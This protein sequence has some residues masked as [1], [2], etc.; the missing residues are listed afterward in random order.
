MKREMLFLG[1]AVLAGLPY[2]PTFAQTESAAL[3]TAGEPEAPA[4]V[5]AEPAATAKGPEMPN[6]IFMLIDDERALELELGFGRSLPTWDSALEA[7]LVDKGTTFE[8]FFNSTAYC[9][10]SRASYLTGMYS[11]NH[12]IWGNNYNVSLGNGGWRRFWELGHE[13]NS[14]GKWMQDAGYQTVLIGKFLNQYPNKPSNFLPETYVPAGWHEWYGSFT[15]DL[16]FSYFNFRMNQNGEVLRFGETEPAYLTDIERDLMV[17]YIQR[18]AQSG[19]PF[20][21]YL[22]PFAPHGPIEVA[23]RHLGMHSIP[24]PPTPPSFNEA[25]LSDKPLYVQEGGYIFP[26]FWS[27]GW[28]QRLDMSLALDEMI[29]ALFDTLAAEGVLDNTYVFFTSDN[30]LMWGEHQLDGKA[31]P[32]EESIRFPLLVR[33]PGVAEGITRNQLVA[34]VDVAPTLLEIANAAI[35]ASVDGESILGLIQGESQALDN[36]RDGVLVELNM[37]GPSRGE[38]EEPVVLGGEVDIVPSYQAVRTLGHMYIEYETGERELYDLVN[39]PYQMES[40]H[41]SAPATVLEALQKPLNALKDC[42]GADCAAASRLGAPTQM[43]KAEF[44]YLCHLL[45]CDFDASESFDLDGTLVGFEW[46]FG[47]GQV[48]SGISVQHTF[49]VASTFDVTL[50]VIDDAGGFG[51]NSQSITPIVEIFENG[52][53]SGDTSLWGGHSE[54]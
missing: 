18:N 21:M 9:C 30:G 5:E 35:P 36:W 43:P 34:N 28:D 46:D 14:V 40:Q 3:L 1:G 20:F 53:E 19:Q 32:Y 16:P 11:H 25:D 10:P 27:S 37:A 6:I 42:S 38:D 4:V 24:D 48:G 41:D 52:F 50:R 13:N 49:S 29:R 54:P 39:D 7:E 47:D 45:L 17:D 26:S 22:A 23:P 51:T 15:N 33:G 44:A 2:S 8:N 31:V 12:G